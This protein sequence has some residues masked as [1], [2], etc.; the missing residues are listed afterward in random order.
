CLIVSHKP[1]TVRRADL[2][3]VL[4]GGRVIEKGSHEELLAGGGDY[5]RLHDRQDL[6][7]TRSR[8]PA[9]PRRWKSEVDPID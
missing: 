9:S 4:D 3:L 6:D 1:A 2:I 8:T 5:A 7:P